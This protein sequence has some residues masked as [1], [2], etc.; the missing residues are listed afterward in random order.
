MVSHAAGKHS[1]LANR[2]PA[3]QRAAQLFVGRGAAAA[4][5]AAAGP[6]L[7]VAGRD[8]AAAERPVAGQHAQRGGRLIRRHVGGAW[9]W[10]GPSGCCSTA[11]ASRAG[12]SQARP[13]MDVHRWARG[14]HACTVARNK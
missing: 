5:A 3:G 7:F 6:A 13:L 10:G 11:V 4:A 9:G 12:S 1:R 8:P 14:A 2:Q